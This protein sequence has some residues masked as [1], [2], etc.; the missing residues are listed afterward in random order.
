MQPTAVAAIAGFAVVAGVV[1]GFA[2]S[3][4]YTSNNNDD[5]TNTPPTATITIKTT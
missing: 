3:I 4:I 5:E 1:D 2:V